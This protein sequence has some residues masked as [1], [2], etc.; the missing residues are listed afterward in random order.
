[1]FL[2]F[3]FVLLFFGGVFSLKEERVS[4]LRMWVGTELQSVGAWTL[5]NIGRWRNVYSPCS[6]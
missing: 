5:K 3:G 2:F 1:M 4:E 6:G